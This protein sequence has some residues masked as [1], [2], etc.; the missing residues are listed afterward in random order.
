MRPLPHNSPQRAARLVPN[1][2]RSRWSWAGTGWQ[3]LRALALVLAVGATVQWMLI[4]TE[5]G[6]QLSSPAAIAYGLFCLLGGGVVLTASGRFRLGRAITQGTG[7]CAFGLATAWAWAFLGSGDS[8]ADALRSALN[9]A[10]ALA[11]LIALCNRGWPLGA[12]FGMLA[13][14][15]GLLAVADALR[16]QEILAGA[17]GLGLP[18]ALSF[19]GIALVVVF[20]CAGPREQE[21][22]NPSGRLVVLLSVVA[23]IVAVAALVYDHYSRLDTGTVLLA[24]LTLLAAALRLLVAQRGWRDARAEVREVEAGA[25]ESTA[26]DAALTVGP[27]GSVLACNERAY[28]TLRRNDFEIVGKPVRNLLGGREDHVFE[29]LLEEVDPHSLPLELSAY[30]T[31][32]MPYPVEVTIRPAPGRNAL[33]TLLVRDITERKRREEEN[34]RLAAI[35]RSSHDAVLTKDL[36][37]VVTG[38]NQGAE[39]VYGYSAE[40]AIGRRV[41]ELLIPRSRRSEA[42]RILKEA[43]A[44]RVVS[45]ETQRLT[46]GGALLDVTLRSFPIRGVS[47]EVCAVCTVAH[48]VSDRRR[49]ERAESRD[50]EGLLWRKR[51]RES[52]D[53]DRLLFHGQPILDLRSGAIHHY[54][55]LMRMEVDGELVMPG[56]FLPY[57]EETELIHELDLWAVEEGMRA[58]EQ[59]SVAINLSARSLGSR[60]LLKA[61]ESRLAADGSLAQRLIFEITETAAAENM[62]GARELVGE[63]T[64]MGCGVALDD[65]GTGYGSFTYLRHLP[66]TQLKID[67][68]FIRGI[69]S[70]QADRRV[71]ESM[72]AV[73]H[74]FEMTTVAEG[75]EDEDTLEELRE[76]GVDLAQGFHIGHPAPLRWKAGGRR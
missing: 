19:G 65:F 36:S 13:A 7:V 60:A 32:G 70:G 74:N 38:W 64:K 33:K 31:Q 5:G 16:A 6:E 20:A 56:T 8:G 3:P 69:A 72:I 10:L 27:D 39:R 24:G 75:V 71:V 45:F 21:R 67:T 48:D 28:R 1:S 54:E 43:G 17:P 29:Q 30:D 76:L 34:R 15:L 40:E 46:K 57:A 51:L 14:G 25:L 41:T 12:R 66:V 53:G 49:R 63:L 62:Q 37:S 42:K 18:D 4:G 22:R 61:I 44:G 59:T 23:A 35:I 50:A 58:G 55:L 47:G 26:L 52:L 2:N 68:E 73:A 9:L 11:V